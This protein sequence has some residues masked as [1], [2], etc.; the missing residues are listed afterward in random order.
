M[1]TKLCT[2]CRH[3][4]GSEHTLM[5]CGH[6][7]HLSPVN[8][9]PHK[10]CWEMRSDMGPCGGTR[11]WEER[12]AAAAAPL[13]PVVTTPPHDPKIDTPPVVG[14]AE[15]ALAVERA[16]TAPTDSLSDL[17]HIQPEFKK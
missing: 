2:G 11:L 1:T 5:L 16:R 15:A 7:K 4:R 13:A 8:G 14:P 12:T 17:L 9:H 3:S 6:P 10:K